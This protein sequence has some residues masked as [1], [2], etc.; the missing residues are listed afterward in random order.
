MSQSLTVDLQEFALTCTGK[1]RLCRAELEGIRAEPRVDNFPEYNR[2]IDLRAAMKEREAA[3]WEARA[4]EARKGF[5]LIDESDLKWCMEN[6]TLVA[7]A[8]AESR[9][10]YVLPIVGPDPIAALKNAPLPVWRGQ[11]INPDGSPVMVEGTAG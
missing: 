1:A 2:E 5:L 8:T 6:H 3:A 11:G 10:T 9:V 7:R 4:T